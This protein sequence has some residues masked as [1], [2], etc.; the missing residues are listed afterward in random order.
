MRKVWQKVFE[1]TSAHRA[2]IVRAILETEGLN[3]VIV[4]LKDSS[5]HFGK[6]EVRVD[7]MHVLEAIG[8]IKKDINFE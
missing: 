3:P 5:Y 6:F 1:D 4:D 2:E 7:S 8:I